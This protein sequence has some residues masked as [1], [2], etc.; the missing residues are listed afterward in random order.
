MYI[1]LL[2]RSELKH[3]QSHI[4]F[5][6]PCFAFIERYCSALVSQRTKSNNTGP[7]QGCSDSDTFSCHGA[8]SA[9]GTA[10]NIHETHMVS[11]LYNDRPIP[12]QLAGHFGLV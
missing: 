7:E 6:L 1:T 4:K 3:R 9:N 11:P 2:A 10:C 5:V 8:W 12:T